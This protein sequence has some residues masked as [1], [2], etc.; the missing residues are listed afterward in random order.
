MRPLHI[1]GLL[2]LAL[3]WGSAYMFMRAS[4]PAFGA[5]PMI[6]L[7]MAL[8]SL[9]VLLPLLAY[10][11]GLSTI[12]R[13]WREMALVG[14]AFTAIPFLGLGLAARVTSAGMLAI[15]Q[16]TAPIFAAI[17]AHFWLKERLNGMRSFGLTLAFLGV[18]VLVWDKVSMRDGAGLGILITLAAT[19]IWGLSSNYTRA[20]L[21]HIDPLALAAGSISFAAL[22]LAPLA[23][24]NW[25]Q[26]APGLRAWLEIL[27]LGVISSGLGFFIYFRLIQ[28]VGAMR[29][30][31]V[32]FLNP[33]VA[34]ASAAAYLGEPITA[35]MLFAC[36][37]ILT[38]T[39]ISLGLI[40]ARHSRHSASVEQS[41]RS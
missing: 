35:R 12:P 8:A 24:L 18:I 39:A 6:F 22:L 21:S 11:R 10:R 29:S 7:R 20:R 5:A 30:V 19:A 31:S 16:A 28:K 37:V 32:T 33:I 9:C 34:M 2:F 4:V 27:F 15:L 23:Y 13:Y 17:V 25:P 41:R 3:I 1:A 38:G 14:I 26:Q 40:G 36:G